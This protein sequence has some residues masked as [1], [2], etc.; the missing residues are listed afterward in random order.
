MVGAGIAFLAAGVLLGLT[1]LGQGM[2]LDHAIPGA[3]KRLLPPESA[4]VRALS[5][6]LGWPHGAYATALLPVAATTVVLLGEV[7]RHGVRPGL[8][9]WRWIPLTLAVIPAHYMLRIAFGR[10]GPGDPRADADLVGSYPSGAALAVGLGWAF[11]L[12]VVGE[13]RPRWRPWVMVLAVFALVIHA[14][15][16]VVTA[17]HWATDVLGSY[18]LVAGAF[19]L[20]STARRERS[21]QHA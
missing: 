20:A 2:W 7:R 16:R 19:L 15:V 4:L 10:P 13:L 8:D 14:A 3:V 12:V 18:L 6:E 1:T 5:S 21:R 9:R 17:K 11:Y